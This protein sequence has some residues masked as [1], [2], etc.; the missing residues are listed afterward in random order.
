MIERGIAVRGAA[1]AGWPRPELVGGRRPDVLGY[2]AAGG[3][4][5]AGEAKRG[6]ELW[7]CRAQLTDIARALPSRGPVGGGALLI[8]GVLPGWETE[9]MELCSLIECPR[10]S[11][12]V[13]SPY[14]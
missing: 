12:M 2:Y 8:L 10:T 6:P 1:A 5:V 9:A 4:V 14:G 7:S 11:S 13:W 3:T